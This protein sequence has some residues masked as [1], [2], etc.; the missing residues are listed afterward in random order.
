M[1]RY[2]LT[3]ALLLPAPTH[4]QPVSW[5]MAQCGALMDV[6]ED[7]VHQQ[8]QKQYLYEAAVLMAAAARQQSQAEGRNPAEL[9]K[10]Q[11][12]KRDAWVDMG[13]TMAF[14]AEF[15][16]WVDYCQ[17]LA[18]SYDIKLHKSMLR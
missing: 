11:S 6:M 2:V 16:D 1:F 3:A 9:V 17:S 10:V 4:A 14:K 8:P 15:G 13:N 7:Y 18:K 5:G 12:A